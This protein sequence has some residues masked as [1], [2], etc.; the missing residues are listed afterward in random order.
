MRRGHHSEEDVGRSVISW[1]DVYS[2]LGS[3]FM[4]LFFIG[5]RLRLTVRKRY[6]A[7]LLTCKQSM[8]A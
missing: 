4:E 8:M 3:S 5:N 7:I 6:G 2:V 1:E